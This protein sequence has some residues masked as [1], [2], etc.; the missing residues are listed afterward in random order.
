VSSILTP[1]ALKNSSERW[2][3][4]DVLTAVHTLGLSACAKTIM[5]LE[6]HVM[7]LKNACN[8]LHSVLNAMIPVSLTRYVDPSLHFLVF[9]WR[10]PVEEV[11]Q[12]T[13][14]LFIATAERQSVETRRNFA[15]T[16]GQQCRSI[17]HISLFFFFSLLV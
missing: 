4:S 16:W 6:D 5:K 7:P 17:P 1:A 2:Q 3:Y 15:R 10:D 13:R 9:Y 8:Q 11:Q 14:M 12:A